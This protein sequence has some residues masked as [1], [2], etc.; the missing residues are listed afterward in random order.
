MPRKQGVKRPTILDVARLAGVS[1]TTVSF[2]INN[3]TSANI[4]QE[5]RAR[6]Q[7]AVDQL[8]YHPLEA[9]RSMG[10]RAS[11]VIGMAIPDAYNAHYQEIVA[12]AE[13]YAEQHG[14]SMFLLATNYD[15]AREQRAFQWL[16]QGR[17]DGLVLFPSSDIAGSAQIAEL[18][19][20]GYPIV[21]LSPAGDD[22]ID[23][24]ILDVGPGERLVVDHLIALGHRRIGYIYAVP[25]LPRFT[26]RLDACLQAQRERQL[27]VVAGWIRRCGPAAEEGYRAT[28][29][30]IAGYAEQ[31][32]PTALII[33]NDMVASAV[34]V[35]L[36]E[37]GVA[38]PGAMSVASFDNTR[39]AQC[40]VYPP[41]TTVD[42]ESSLQGEHAVRLVIERLAD[43]QRPPAHVRAH[44]RLVVR[45]STGP[46]PLDR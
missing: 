17:I 18:Q 25:D 1:H 7:A 31:E 6:V 15:P 41:L 42:Y 20:Q 44:A 13:A 14:Y 39:H 8:R 36:A 5:T 34:V 11:R 23:G 27:P 24:V 38:I 43:P 22:Q 19:Q 33:I 12:G 2:V 28:K 40:T 26:F 16:R 9:A 4:S 21:T 3:V 35:A 29:S 32:R 45:Q 46:A 30:L 37:A 10:R